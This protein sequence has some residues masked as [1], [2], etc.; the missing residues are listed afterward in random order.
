MSDAPALEGRS[1]VALNLDKLVLLSL[2]SVNAGHLN[3]RQKQPVLALCLIKTL[4]SK[5]LW[6]STG[7]SVESFL[8]MFA[9]S[10]ATASYGED[11]LWFSFGLPV[12]VVHLS[13]DHPCFIMSSVLEKTHRH[14]SG[15][16]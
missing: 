12:G 11:P 16:C 5:S 6:T 7:E 3:A 15:C 9:V 14:I 1:G 4:I 2:R 13:Q 10:M 8:N